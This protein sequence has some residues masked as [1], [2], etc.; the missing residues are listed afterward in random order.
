MVGGGASLARIL[1][2]AANLTSELDVSTTKLGTLSGKH[3][4]ASEACSKKVIKMHPAGRMTSGRL[5]RVDRN[6]PTMY[7]Y[8]ITIVLV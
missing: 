2:D 6:G 5:I 4:L 7:T 3:T 1:F 8:S